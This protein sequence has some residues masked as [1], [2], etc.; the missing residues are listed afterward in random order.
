MTQ[1]NRKEPFFIT[2]EIEAELIAAGHVFELP[3]IAFT[4]RLRDVLAR[5]ARTLRHAGISDNKNGP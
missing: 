3:A 1:S 4:S 2:E 5:M